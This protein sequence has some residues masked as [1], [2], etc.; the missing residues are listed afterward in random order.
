MKAL[1]TGGSG[2]IGTAICRV[3]ASAGYE[4][5]VGY[6]RRKEAAESLA[7]ELGGPTRRSC[8]L[9]LDVAD[10]GP[11]RDAVERLASAWGGLDA[12][13]HAAARS[14][15]GLL[16]DLAPEDILSMFAVNVAGA[17]HVN[18]AAL[19]WLL[20]SARARIV[21]FSSVLATRGIPG[22]TLYAGTKGAIEAVT[23]T[24]AVELGPKRVTVNAI[25]PGFVDAG[26]G[27]APLAAAGGS[28][29]SVVPLRRAATAEEIAGVVAFLLSEEARYVNGAVIAV[30]GGLL[31]GSRAPEEPRHLEGVPS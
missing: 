27:R 23:R 13:V 16:S 9:Y 11:T 1:V 22:A 6:H 2:G 18:Q 15:D 20:S 5:A 12:V 8:S 4:V 30:D 10:A 21:H 19:P 31:A 25:A 28:L 24:L 17:M 3:L 7:A 29:R 26:L 14:V